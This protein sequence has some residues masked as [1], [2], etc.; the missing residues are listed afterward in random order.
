MLKRC[1]AIGVAI[2]C[3][4]AIIAPSP[5]QA[6]PLISKGFLPQNIKRL[7]VRYEIE[8]IDPSSAEIALEGTGLTTDDSGHLLVAPQSCQPGERKVNGS[9]VYLWRS[10]GTDA[11]GDRIDVR[12]SIRNITVVNPYPDVTDAHVL[13]LGEGFG[14]YD[15]PKQ[16]GASLQA[17]ALR[18]DKNGNL[19]E[20]PATRLGADVE[21]ELNITKT[22]TDTPASGNFVFSARGLN[23]ID[24]DMPA[25]SEQIELVDGFSDAVSVLSDNTLAITDENTRYTAKE[26]D[27]ESYRGGFAT[28][29]D[30]AKTI[31]RW[32]GRGCRQLI[33]DNFS[34]MNV[35]VKTNDH[36]SVICEGAEVTSKWPMEW[37]GTSKFA[38]VPDPGYR[39]PIYS[40]NGRIMGETVMWSYSNATANILLELTFQ[41]YEYSIAYN[42]GSIAATGSMPPQAASGNQEIVIQECAFANEGYVFIGWNTRDD[43]SGDIYLPGQSVVNLASTHKQTVY[44]YAQWEPLIRVSVP[45]EATCLVQADGTVISPERWQIKNLSKVSVKTASIEA[46]ET[47][48]GVGIMLS[49]TQNLPYF[50]LEANGKEKPTGNVGTL[51]SGESETYIWSLKSDTTSW[52]TLSG[53][54]LAAVL[55]R[56]DRP[57]TVGAVTFTFE[58]A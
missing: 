40:V 51:K 12:L 8:H 42:P 47:I 28:H 54:S 24:E 27:E 30:P 2:A 13:L 16:G 44:L 7:D 4:S 3:F 36:G 31:F 53:K 20:D 25:W 46:A 5:A 29:A 49:S 23:G 45:I 50:Q 18:P 17:T 58:R 10:C 21:V 55:T 14:V 22:R 38:F 56:E 41:L 19:A 37:K 32:K 15:R 57:R 9:A 48:P 34:P 1:L 43:G 39:K 11:D 33:L 35:S 26:G 52:G 6:L